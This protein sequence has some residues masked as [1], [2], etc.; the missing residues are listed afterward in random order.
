[1]NYR[2]SVAARVMLSYAGVIIVFGAAVALSIGRLAAFNTS[3]SDITGPQV[4]NLELAHDWSDALS[5]SMRHTR[6]ML[7]MDDKAEIQGE[8]E[9][10]RALSQKRATL[11]DGMKAAVQSAE[12]KALLQAAFDAREILTPLDED[13]LRQVQA[14]DIKAARE[15]LL[16]RSR[17]A[18]LAVIG[19]LKK[20]T[21]YEQAN[22]HGKADELAAAYQSTRTL[23][24]T[25]SLAA[26]AVACLLAWLLTRAIKKPLNH[27]VA[28]LSEIEKGNYANTVTVSSHD[29]IGQTLRGLERMQVALRERT[30]KEHEAAM[31]NAR[32]RTALD[33]VSVG[34]MLGDTDGKI[35]YTN[36]AL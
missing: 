17:P 19:A 2:N 12:G 11:A 4:A 23:L 3:V 8:I 15:T 6:N 22:I 14:G 21:E 34:A 26:V 24:I 31:E 36:D 13:F 5:E 29:E 27:A 10:V 9:K 20:L 7:I 28:V 16:L 33:R 1:M 18:Q 25:L 32:I 30:D 35:I